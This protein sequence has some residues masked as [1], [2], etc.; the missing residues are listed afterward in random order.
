MRTVKLTFLFLV[1]CLVISGFTSCGQSYEPVADGNQLPTSTVTYQTQKVN[2][3]DRGLGKVMYTVEIPSNWQVRQNIYTNPQNGMVQ[4]FQLDYSGPG[5]ELIRV[6][7]P[8]MFYSQYGQ[9]FYQTWNQMI[10]QSVGSVLSNPQLGDLQP[11]QKPLAANSVKRAMRQFPGNF[12]GYEQAISGVVNGQPFAGKASIV[13]VTNQMGGMVMATVAIAPQ[14]RLDGTLAVLDV[15]NGTL[16]SNSE[17]YRQVFMQA[18]QRGLAAN[19]AAHNQTMAQLH[20]KTQRMYQDLSD[21]QSRDNADF[22]NRMRS[23]G[24][25]YNGNSH[26]ANDQFN[27]YLRDVYTIENPYS[28]LQ[29]Q[30]NN[31]YEYW[32]VNAAGERRGTNDPNLDLTNVP[33]GTWKRAPRARND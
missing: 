5:G 4:A 9:N 18:G 27:D 10:R 7:K 13:H 14:G 3:V 26:T 1:F 32:F 24:L 17:A 33:G 15:M 6:A 31:T 30:V 8:S 19:A 25:G 21:V 16:S 2:I 12:R 23:S 11:S 20:A 22:S 28:G 29:E